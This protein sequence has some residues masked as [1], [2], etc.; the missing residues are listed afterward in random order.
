MSER[1]GRSFCRSANLDAVVQAPIASLSG[2]DRSSHAGPEARAT[3]ADRSC[4]KRITPLRPQAAQSRSGRICDPLGIICCP[5]GLN[6]WKL[7]L[8]LLA[9]CLRS[10][11]SR[12]RAPLQRRRR[13]ERGHSARR[14]PPR[15]PRSRPIRKRCNP[16]AANR[17]GRL[18]RGDRPS[19][20]GRTGQISEVSCESPQQN[21][22]S[23]TQWQPTSGA[24]TWAQ[25]PAGARAPPNAAPGEACPAS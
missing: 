10:R 3:R 9:G 6:A 21:G 11:I 7:H 16:E 24:Q 12:S 22:L 18:A 17:S 25:Q 23:A 8:S 4:R 5:C 15:R 13:Q 1:C 2:C 20:A 14:I 19:G